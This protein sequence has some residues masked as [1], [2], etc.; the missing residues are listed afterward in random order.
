MLGP[1]ALAVRAVPALL[2]GGD[3][4][5]LA[6]S[7]LAELR[8]A[9]SIA[10]ARAASRR[11]CSRRWP[12]TVQCAPTAGSVCDEMN[13]LLRDM[14]ATAGRRPVQPRSPDLGAGRACRISIAGSCAA[15]E[16]D[17]ADPGADRLG[18]ERDR[19]G[20]RAH[21]AGG[22]RERRLGARLP[23]TWTSAPP[24]PRARSATRCLTTWSTSSTPRRRIPPRA[25]RRTRSA[26]SARSARAGGC[27]CWWA[28]P[29][30]TR[31]P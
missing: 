23:A 31:G 7:V 26:S 2:A 22:D 21:D 10:R 18:Q 20:D 12:A 9:G 11:S 3:A 24:S 14:E 15:A 30:S 29:C 28:A 6:R 27:R 1:T 17:T 4:V 25:S 16:R 13:A 5:A 8:E 19:D